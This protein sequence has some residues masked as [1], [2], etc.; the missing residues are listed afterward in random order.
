MLLLAPFLLR[1]KSVHPPASTRTS[2]SH[3]ITAAG[4]ME[5][6]CVVNGGKERARLGSCNR[7]S[8][9]RGGYGCCDLQS[10]HRSAGQGMGGRGE[11]DS[12]VV[13]ICRRDHAA[14]STGRGGCTV[15]V[16]VHFDCL[17][18]RC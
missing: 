9:R 10:M 13:S 12:S 11:G 17:V 15:Q 18:W 8:R 5:N 6:F 14:K 4:N 16:H 3:T 2:L 1:T 7:D